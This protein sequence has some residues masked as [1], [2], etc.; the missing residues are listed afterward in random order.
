[1]NK[2]MCNRPKHG[3]SFVHATTLEQLFVYTEKESASSFFLYSTGATTA[4]SKDAH[5]IRKEKGQGAGP[6]L[7]EEPDDYAV[8]LLF[9]ALNK[10]CVLIPWIALAQDI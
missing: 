6:Q 10:Q 5:T 7:S 3:D 9:A 8:L 2:A 4:E 1:M